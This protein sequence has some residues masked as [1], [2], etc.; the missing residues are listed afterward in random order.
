M[1]NKRYYIELVNRLYFLL[2]S[3]ETESMEVF[4]SRATTLSYDFQ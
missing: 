2:V 4:M 3:F 1:K